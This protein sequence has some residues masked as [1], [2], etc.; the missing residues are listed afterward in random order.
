M[1]VFAIGLTWNNIYAILSTVPGPE[2][3]SINVGNFHSSDKI[4]RCYRVS[5]H[6]KRNLVNSV[7]LKKPQILM[8]YFGATYP[9]PSSMIT[10]TPYSAVY[11]RT[12]M[13]DIRPSK[14]KTQQNFREGRKRQW[15]DLKTTR[16]HESP[17]YSR[18][19]ILNSNSTSCDTTTHFSFSNPSIGYSVFFKN[20]LV[21]DRISASSFDRTGWVSLV[22]TSATRTSKQLVKGKRLF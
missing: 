19:K 10:D 2:E 17:V 22:I 13:S 9:L 12:C 3:G 14:F 4:L 21:T 6:E 5:Q 18:L 16:P 11:Q 7:Q 1:K 20:F 15:K 8:G